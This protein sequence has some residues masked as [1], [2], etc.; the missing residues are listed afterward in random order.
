MNKRQIIPFV[1]LL[2]AFVIWVY[3]I[4]KVQVPNFTEHHPTYIA[5]E[6]LSNHYD[7]SGFNDYQIFADKMISYPEDDITL[8]ELPRVVVHTKDKETGNVTIWQLTST[9]GTLENK[10]KLLLSEGVIIE[11]LT[12]NEIV[13]EMKTDKAIVQ[14]DKQEVTTEL[15]VI[16]TGP[17]I[18]QE[19][20]GMWVSLATKEMKLN[21]NIK[22]VYFNEPK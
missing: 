1:A 13:Q 9:K 11:N 4:P 8:F 14:L 10:N 12:K 6:V 2:A 5:N 17:Q 7:A 22:A 21:S 18:R 19:G 20:V 16:W 3:I 15:Q